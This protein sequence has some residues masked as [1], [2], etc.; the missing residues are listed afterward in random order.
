MGERAAEVPE[1]NVHAKPTSGRQ[2]VRPGASQ[3]HLPDEVPRLLLR[4][5]LQLL[6]RRERPNPLQDHRWQRSTIQ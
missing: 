2:M 3:R 5:R 6:N 4:R 1:P